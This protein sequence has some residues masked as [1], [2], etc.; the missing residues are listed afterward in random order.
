MFRCL[1][2][3]LFDRRDVSLHHTRTSLVARF[4]PEAIPGVGKLELI[5]AMGWRGWRGLS[6]HPYDIRDGPLA[7]V[8]TRTD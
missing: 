4:V 2:I 6:R 7:W 3:C 8:F 5:H 1:L